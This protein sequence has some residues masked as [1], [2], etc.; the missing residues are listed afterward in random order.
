ME[1]VRYRNYLLLKSKYLETAKGNLRKI[2][3]ETDI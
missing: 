2:G 3:C 1:N